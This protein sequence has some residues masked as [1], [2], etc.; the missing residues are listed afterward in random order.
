MIPALVSRMQIYE[1]RETGKFASTTSS[2]SI[3]HTLFQSSNW[4]Q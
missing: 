4:N 2:Y 3:F 1:I